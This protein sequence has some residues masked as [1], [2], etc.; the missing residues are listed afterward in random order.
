MRVLGQ[1]WWGL[2]LRGLLSI[3]FGIALFVWPGI[4]LLA[5][6]TLFA[7]FAFVDGVL[8]LV[9]AFRVRAGHTRWWALLLEGIVGI[10]VGVL[11]L[12]WPGLT[13][14]ALVY[15]IAAWAVVTGIFE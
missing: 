8:A 12:I 1:T 10:A 3:L 9:S 6:I 4:S 2:A 13:A 7:A 15:V 5:L 11:A 14:T